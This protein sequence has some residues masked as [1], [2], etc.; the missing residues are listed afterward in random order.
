MFMKFFNPVLRTAY[1]VDRASGERQQWVEEKER[2]HVWQ[3]LLREWNDPPLCTMCK[4]VF[5]EESL[6]LQMWFLRVESKDF[7]SYMRKE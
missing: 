5:P 6:G 7:G 3:F 1:S 4:A 2:A